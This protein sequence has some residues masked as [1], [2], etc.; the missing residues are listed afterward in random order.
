[1]LQRLDLTTARTVL[2]EKTHKHTEL[3]LNLINLLDNTYYFQWPEYPESTLFYKGDK[4]V[5]QINEWFELCH[6][7]Y[8]AAKTCLPLKYCWMTEDG[9]EAIGNVIKKLLNI[10]E[11]YHFNIPLSLPIATSSFVKGYVATAEEERRNQRYAN[12]PIL[13]FD[14]AILR[15]AGIISRLD[16]YRTDLLEQLALRQILA[17]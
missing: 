13:S 10:P 6:M 12:R 2:F 8:E 5:F 9:Q 1:M 11:Y 4:C 15:G 17:R 7:D 3:L 14:E 16:D